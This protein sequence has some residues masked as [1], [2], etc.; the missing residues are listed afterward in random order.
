MHSRS[1]VMIESTGIFVG[2]VILLNT[3]L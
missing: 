1:K 3:S 2:F